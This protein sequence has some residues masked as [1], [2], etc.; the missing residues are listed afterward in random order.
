MIAEWRRSRGNEGARAAADRVLKR[1]QG[2]QSLAAAMAAEKVAL[3]APE[4]VNLSREELARLGNTSVPAPI[5]L[6]FAMAEGS[7][8]KLKGNG[9]QGW[10]VVSLEDISLG[11]LEE[12]DPLVQQALLQIAQGWTAEYSQQ[13]LAAMRAE[14]GV[15]RNPDAIAAVRRQLLGETN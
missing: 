3:P 10:F 12:N 7:T 2:G 6:M 15:E 4:A 13:M 14:V 9:D 11:Q 8:K 1:V 5:A